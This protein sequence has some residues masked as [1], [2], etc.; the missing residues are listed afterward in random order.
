[1]KRKHT[2]HQPF[3]LGNT[4]KR[5]QQ[6][7][8]ILTPDNQTESL[9]GGAESFRPPANERSRAPPQGAA[10]RYRDID[11]TPPSAPLTVPRR[12]QEQEYGG[13]EYGGLPVNLAVFIR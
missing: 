10:G 13:T 4:S 7:T 11:R 2:T 6:G 3:P 8:A 5:E 1:V 9:I 12:P